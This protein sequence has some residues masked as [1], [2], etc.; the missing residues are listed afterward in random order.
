MGPAG[1]GQSLLFTDADPEKDSPKTDEGGVVI[2]LGFD[3]SELAGAPGS[4]WAAAKVGAP[5]RKVKVE[6]PV[7]AKACKPKKVCKPSRKKTAC[8]P[9]A[10]R[11]YKYCR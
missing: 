3:E 1:D 11:K 2:I 5:V 10:G 9:K 7:T 6:P 4:N 8:R